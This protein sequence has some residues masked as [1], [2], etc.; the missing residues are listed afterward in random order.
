VTRLYGVLNDAR[1]DLPHP[2]A[3]VIDPGGIVRYWRQ[4]VDFTRR[5]PT[6]ELLAAVRAL[7]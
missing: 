7:P 3:L 2:T 1:G 6:S 4:D 5:P